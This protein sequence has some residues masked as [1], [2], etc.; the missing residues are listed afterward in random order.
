MKQCPVCFEELTI[1]DC[2]P[3]DDCGCNQTE[4]LHF[5]E[6]KHTYK[7]YD[8]HKGLHLTLCD[9]CDVDFGSYD[10]K[11][12]GFENG[13]QLSIKNFKFIKEIENPKISKDM[14]CAKCSHKINFLNFVFDI[15]A[16]NKT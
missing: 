5:K 13:Y 8:V 6:N 12:F 9:F 15:R 10:S 14:F 1:Q 16:L 3:C 4:I 7:I 2:A 11:Y